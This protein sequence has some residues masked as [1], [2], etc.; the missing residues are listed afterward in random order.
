MLFYS[1]LD[2]V[3]RL[4]KQYIVWQEIF[5]NGLE[6]LPNTV[7]DVWKKGWEDEMK[8]VTASGLHAILSTCWYLND[9]SYGADWTKYYQCD[10]QNFNGTKEEQEL[11][12][13]GHCCL[14]GEFVDSTNFLTR[15]WP[16]AGAVGERL[17]SPASVTDV[18]DAGVR[19]HNFRCRMLSRG[20]PAEPPDG[21]S[22]CTTE[23]NGITPPS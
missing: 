13:G 21:P 3:A 18:N 1:L 23:W 11:V 15:Y 22:F 4:N 7:I 6:V 5:D 10:P 2:L 12:V 9:I 8:R 14:W 16:R 20:I 19:L 17:W